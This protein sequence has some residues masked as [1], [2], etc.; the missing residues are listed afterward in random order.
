MTPAF[1][2][3]LFISALLW[4]LNVGQLDGSGN[5]FDYKQEIDDADPMIVQD[6]FLYY[7]DYKTVYVNC[8]V[9]G[10]SPFEVSWLY[11]TDEISNRSSDYTII[12]GS[13]VSNIV[14]NPNSDD[15]GYTWWNSSLLLN[16]I[17]NSTVGYYYCRVNT[18]FGLNYS[19]PVYVRKPDLPR[20]SSTKFNKIGDMVFGTWRVI[21]FPLPNILISFQ[22]LS[23][24]PIYQK[25][26]YNDYMTANVS[27]SFYS[28]SHNFT[29]VN[30]TNVNSLT[31]HWSFP[32]HQLFSMQ[33][34]AISYDCSS[35]KEHYHQLY[36]HSGQ[37]YASFLSLSS[38]ERKVTFSCLCAECDGIEWRRDNV[39]LPKSSY[40]VVALKKEIW[41]SHSI[42]LKHSILSTSF[43]DSY[44]Y[45][46]QPV[47]YQSDIFEI[48]PAYIDVP[49]AEIIK[50]PEASTYV[51]GETLT[52]K[53]SAR[54]LYPMTVRWQKSINNLFST[55]VKTDSLATEGLYNVLNSTISFN[56]SIMTLLSFK[57]RCIFFTYIYF[58]PDNFAKAHGLYQKGLLFERP[59][60]MTVNKITQNREMTIQCKPI[61]IKTLN[62]TSILILH[63]SI[64]YH[65]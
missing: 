55:I 6:P 63:R 19:K 15:E 26:V 11:S 22:L 13:K 8:S 2:L 31:V 17:N 28:T 53:C 58:Q 40:G 36:N 35:Q 3:G 60:P 25:T 38:T 44:L 5:V 4:C 27:N 16:P 9:Y 56:I 29:Y 20:L 62:K 57:M 64:I 59:K 52:Q 39:P 50:R 61:V 12:S 1:F 32:F 10:E 65:V 51:P 21:S 7:L 24:E 34:I 46:C 23:S 18:S 30:E 33:L 41:P 54:S 49:H 48:I 14:Y 42:N 43:F 47:Y 45:S 37:A